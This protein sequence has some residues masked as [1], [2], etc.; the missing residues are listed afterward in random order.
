MRLSGRCFIVLAWGLACGP[1]G[2]FLDAGPFDTGPEPATGG[3]AAATAAGGAG[4]AGNGGT[5][6]AGGGTGG[7]TSAG[8]A[9]GEGG[10]PLCGPPLGA[11]AYQ[12]PETW[13]CYAFVDVPRIWSVARGICITWGGD[14]AAP[15]TAAE[16]AALFQFADLDAFLSGNPDGARAWTGGN[17]RADEQE[18]V[19]SNGEPWLA[20]PDGPDWFGDEPNG[21]MMQNCFTTAHDGLLR[22]RKCTDAL[23]FLCEK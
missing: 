8:G 16:M 20:P 21:G 5:A 6:G 17:D 22:D 18:N 3:A 9:G 19:W 7:T 23:P 13:R 1:A 15:S 11:V 4:A 2:C 10:A 12:D 14:L